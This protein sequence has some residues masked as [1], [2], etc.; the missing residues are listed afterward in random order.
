MGKQ[1]A[2]QLFQAGRQVTVWNRSRAAVEELVERGARRA[3]EVSETFQ[4]DILLSILFDGEAIRTVLLGPQGLANAKPG[5]IHAC[6]TTVSIAMPG[7]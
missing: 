7:S 1:M 2:L 3:T 6:A 5:C 4:G